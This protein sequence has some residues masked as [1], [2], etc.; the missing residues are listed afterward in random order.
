MKND[1][2][3]KII[4]EAV[5]KST[6]TIFLLLFGLYAGANEHETDS[7]DVEMRACVDRALPELSMTQTLTV[8]VIGESGRN[9]ET[10]RTLHWK[11]FENGFSKALIR[12]IAP[13]NEA[14]LAVLLVER[15][16]IEPNIFMF[17]PEL[18]RAR[19]VAGAAITGS[20][21]GTDISYEDFTHFM[22]IIKSSEYEYLEDTEL[23]SAAAYLLET[24]PKDERSGYSKI[25]TY[26]DKELCLP[27]KSEF[28]SV[29]GSLDKELSIDRDAV[30]PVGNRQIPFR[31]IMVNHKNNTRSE[32]IVKEVE[33]D[34]NI[35][36][37][38]FTRTELKRGH[39]GH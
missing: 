14:G 30:Q 2:I 35:R 28:Y 3:E 31:S 17:T 27:I 29:N 38:M 4:R 9:R 20:I 6:L 36:D 1:P 37:S 25:R 26:M 10:T 18:Q 16:G 13:T 23:E 19:R 15:E 39:R 5:Q 12:I 22:K 21:M 32:F 34:P 11:R 24:I 33:V 7:Q 8:N